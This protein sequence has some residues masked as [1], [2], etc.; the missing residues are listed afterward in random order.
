M[1]LKA[2]TISLFWPWKPPKSY[3]VWI[4]API[5]KLYAGEERRHHHY[6]PQFPHPKSRVEVFLFLAF[7]N[8]GVCV[9]RQFLRAVLMKYH[10]LG[11]S[12]QWNLSTNQSFFWKEAALLVQLFN[13]EHPECLSPTLSSLCILS[14]HL[15]ALSLRCHDTCFYHHGTAAAP[16][17]GSVL[18]LQPISTCCHPLPVTAPHLP[19]CLDQLKNPL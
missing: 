16:S 1:K 14:S 19:P 5:N 2:L 12:E 15:S 17:P 10:K 6:V 4:P 9:F 18:L 7:S 8:H 13:P 11:H 3:S